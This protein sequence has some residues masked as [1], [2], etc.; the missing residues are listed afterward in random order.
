MVTCLGVARVGRR[1]RFPSVLN[2]PLYISPFRINDLRAV[3][4]KRHDICL[5]SLET[6][7]DL[8]ISEETAPIPSADHGIS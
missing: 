8:Q 7:T 6:L 2:R 5:S 3:W 4:K 1:L